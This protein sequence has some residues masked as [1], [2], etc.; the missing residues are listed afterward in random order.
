MPLTGIGVDEPV[1]EAEVEVER[2]YQASV[3]SEVLII[4]DVGE[5][6]KSEMRRLSCGLRSPRQENSVSL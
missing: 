3:G 1:V 2:R 6:G 4:H 5:Q